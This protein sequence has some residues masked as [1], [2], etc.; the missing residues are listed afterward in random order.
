M[1]ETRPAV[2]G[3]SFVD[4]L[5]VAF[6]VLRLV[7]EIDWPWIWV[8]APVWIYIVWMALLGAVAGWGRRRQPPSVQVLRRR[9]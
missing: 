3:A 6:I 1:S 9:W 7:H 2:A 8:L 4:L 5:T